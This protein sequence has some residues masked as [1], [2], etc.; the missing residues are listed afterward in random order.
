[1]AAGENMNLSAQVRK[2]YEKGEFF[3]SDLKMHLNGLKNQTF[4]YFSAS[5]FLI[6]PCIVRWG[7][8][9]S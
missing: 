2:N 4:S 9:N 5:P 1:M 8:G 6:T 3:K 7:G